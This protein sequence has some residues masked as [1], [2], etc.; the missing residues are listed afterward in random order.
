MP[1]LSRADVISTLDQLGRDAFLC[2]V[3][4]F[5]LGVV[6][7]KL[8]VRS[9]CC[10]VDEDSGQLAEEAVKIERSGAQSVHLRRQLA[11]TWAVIEALHQSLLS[12]IKMT[13]RELWYELPCSAAPAL[14]LLL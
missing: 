11:Q 7:I 1:S 6:D 8:V 12:G 3:R 9:R 13:Q 4:D 5:G 10:I 2:I 14:L